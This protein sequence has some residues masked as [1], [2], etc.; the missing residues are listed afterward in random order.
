M[1]NKG[2]DILPMAV[3]IGSMSTIRLPCSLVL[4]SSIITPEVVTSICA[5]GCKYQKAKHYKR[6]LLTPFVI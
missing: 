4:K 2:I 6:S 5:E 3:A 1:D